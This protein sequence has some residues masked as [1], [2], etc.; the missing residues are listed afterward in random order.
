MTTPAR[1]ARQ[2]VANLPALALESAVGLGFDDLLSIIEHLPSAVTVHDLSGRPVLINAAARGLLALPSTS[3]PPLEQLSR[4]LVRCAGTGRPLDDAETPLGRALAGT[5]ARDVDL[6]LQVPGEGRDRWCRVS[7]APRRDAEGR[8]TGA[9]STLAD[10]SQEYQTVTRHLPSGLA[11]MHLAAI[12]S[13]LDDAILSVA[14][15]GIITNWNDGAVRLYGYGAEEM[16]GQHIGVLARLARVLEMPEWVDRILRGEGVARNETVWVRKDGAALHVSLTISPVRDDS[17]AI[18]GAAAIARDISSGKRVE[19]QLRHQALHDTLTG[20]P[21]RTLLLDRLQYAMHRAERERESLAMLLI[22]L[23][24]FKEVNDTFG[25]YVGDTLLQVVAAR[26]NKALYTSDTVAR[27]GGDEFSV[28]LPNNDEVGAALVARKIAAALE[29]PIHIQGQAIPAACSIGIALYPQHGVDAETLLRRA[30]VAMYVAK[31]QTQRYAVYAATH[32]QYSPE[33]S[34]LIVDLRAAIANGDLILHY[35][36]QIDLA[37]QRVVGVE[38]L[39]R[40]PHPTR[41]F[42]APD[43]FIPLAEQ[44]NLIAP[45]T[46]A[47]LSEALRQCRDWMREGI[48]LPIAVNL[49]VH[50]LH[51]IDLFPTIWK[52]IEDSGVPPSTL[53]LEVTESSIMANITRTAESL[54]RLAD[55]GVGLSIDDYG[56][57]YSSLAYLKRLPVDELKIDKSFIMDLAADSANAA[58]VVS[59]IRLAH[60]L[61]LRVVAEGVEDHQTWD[62]LRLMGCDVAQGY[63]LSRPLPPRE[64]EDWLRESPWAGEPLERLSS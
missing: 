23:D 5:S 48:H 2:V 55:L 21:N 28:V 61:G 47:V 9:I 26:L 11:R 34:S 53:R 32:D 15:N 13:A 41:G 43:Q 58:I 59:T 54:T 31:R 45:L 6:I 38:A 22:D 51:D 4:Y 20:L 37:T 25:H 39:A 3:R 52:L 49:S 30:D 60:D 42:M 36:P 29:E 1:A 18:I 44:T 8:I 62:R 10:V 33:R 12:V 57:G 27:L 14:L 35:Q 63:Y 50:N 16:V 64:L 24:R 56:T 40:W 19:E 7:A 17:G 46:I